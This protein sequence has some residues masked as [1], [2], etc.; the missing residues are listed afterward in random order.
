MYRAH[1][2]YAEFKE[3]VGNL[4]VHIQKELG[5]SVWRSKERPGM[6]RGELI[7]YKWLAERETAASERLLH[8]IMGFS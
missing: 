5:I 1:F 2:G 4:D 8:K 7:A 3:W 6:G